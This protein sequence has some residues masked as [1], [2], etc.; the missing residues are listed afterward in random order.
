MSVNPQRRNLVMGIA[1]LL[2]AGPAAARL[3]QPTPRQTAGPFYPLQPPLDDDND[4]IQIRGRSGVA[5]GRITDLS[6]RVLDVNGRPVRNLRVEIW[7][8]DANG[9]YHHPR[10]RGRAMDENFQGFGHS[11]TDGIGRYRFRTIRPVPYPGRTPHIHVAV[12]APDTAPF[13]TQ[14]Y[15]RGE[16]R[17]AE[18]FIFNRVPVDRRHMV[19]ADFVP[20]ANDAA[21]LSA[22]FDIVLAGIG[23]TP[24]A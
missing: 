10:D 7:Q 20:A 2:L 4:L 14:L 23:G 16:P 6:G 13:T 12:F 11:V 9:R 17:N 1:G 19:L 24:S 5:Q 3:L 8:C 22:K 21:E 18:D 15:V